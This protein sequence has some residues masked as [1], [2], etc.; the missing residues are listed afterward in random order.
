MDSPR[1]DVLIVVVSYNSLS[2]LHGCLS[3]L[4]AACQGITWHAIV[5]DNA[6]TD[7]S[8]DLVAQQFPSVELIASK[9][10]LGF[11]RGNNVGLNG[12]DARHALLLNP[13]TEAKPLSITRLVQFLDANPKAGACGPRLLNTDGSLQPNGGMLPSPVWEFFVATG[14]RRLAPTWF[15]VRFGHGQVDFTHTCETENVSGAA[16]MMRGEAIEQVGVLDEGLFMYYEELDWCLRAR[17]AGWTVHY[18][19]EAEITHHWMGSVRTQSWR[20]AKISAKSSLHYYR[21]HFSA[22]LFPLVLIAKAFSLTRSWVLWQGAQVKRRIRE[23][24]KQAT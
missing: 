2:Y 16:L 18:V 23:A 13:D 14:I 21:K 10:N 15:N 9:E 19:N 12:F 5:V 3:A 6:S 22:A 8:A 1:L 24:K 17:R 7:G 4:P 11:P 20:A